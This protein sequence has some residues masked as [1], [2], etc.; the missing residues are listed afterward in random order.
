MSSHSND[1]FVNDF[2][3]NQFIDTLNTSVTYF[4]VCTL[5]PVAINYTSKDERTTLSSSGPLVQESATLRSP[6]QANG[7]TQEPW[8][9]A[10]LRHRSPPVGNYPQLRT[11]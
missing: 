4:T 8:K 3:G 10:C 6:T 2:L 9:E 5:L 11:N 7:R 1:D